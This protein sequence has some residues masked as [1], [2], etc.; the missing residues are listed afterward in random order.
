MDNRTERIIGLVFI[1]FAI[2]NIFFLIPRELEK[3]G[4]A[5][6]FPVFLSLIILVLS[7]IIFL[8]T[9]KRKEPE[10]KK[11]EVDKEG[12]THLL[13]LIFLTFCYIFFMDMAGFYILTILFLFIAMSMLG[14]PGF[15]FKSL[16]SV[17]MIGASYI[18]FNVWLGAPLP[19]GRIIEAIIF[20]E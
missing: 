5:S 11:E 9:M 7:S 8:Y 4:A 17:C 12:L 13:L 15:L 1:V 2:M 6:R 3:T 20:G 10:K 16:I 18:I 14:I 19:M